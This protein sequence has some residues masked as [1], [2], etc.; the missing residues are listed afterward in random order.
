MTGAAVA[1]TVVGVDRK[2]IVEAVTKVLFDEGCNL[3]DATSTILRGHFSMM[4]VVTT[5]QSGSEALESRLE[6]ALEPLG[7]SATVRPLDRADPV[8]AAP[9]HTVSVYGADKP[10]IVH[11]VSSALAGAGFNVTE[12]TSRVI[13]G[14]GDVYALLLEVGGGEGHDPQEVLSE[15][16][17]ELQ[18]DI[19]VQP[20]EPDIF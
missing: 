3:Q 10:G 14:E 17:G 11:R 6:M 15:L 12:L 9:T 18:V 1:V 7:V 19:T 4:L 16:A 2:G 20:L 8:V 13:S 5:G